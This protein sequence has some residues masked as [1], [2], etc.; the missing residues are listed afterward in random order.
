MVVMASGGGDSTALLDLLAT[1]TIGED[2]RVH[3]FHLNHGIRSE[4]ADADEAFVRDL[5]GSLAVPLEVLRY[6]V[7]AY[8]AEH[9]LNLEDAGRRLRYR[10]V[11]EHLDALLERTSGRS[12]VGRIATGHTR[13]D[14]VETFFM[15]L[16]QGSGPRGLTSLRH[17]RGRIVRPL[18]DC[19]RDD[20]RT[21]LLSRGLAWREDSSNLDTARLRARVRHDLVPVLEEINPRFEE[22]LER[23]LDILA[24]EDTLL[25]EMAEAFADDFTHMEG[26]ALEFDCEKMATLG[27][28]MKRRVVRAALTRTFPE[29]SRIEYSH[30]EALVAGFDDLAFA[31]DLP[32]GL[33]AFRE[34]GRM[35]VLRS[36]E[37]APSVVPGLL[38]LP[39]TIDLGPAGKIVA[40]RVSVRETGG[41]DMSV[42]VDPGASDEFVV[43]HPR[44]GDKMRPLGLGGTKK[45]SD[46]LID[47][48]VPKRLR[49]ATPVVRDGENIVWVAGVRMSDEYKV[50]DETSDAVRLTWSPGSSSAGRDVD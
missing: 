47:A 34:Y 2:L 31:R 28:P 44:E 27:A 45:L 48:K 43:D 15:R 18:L 41:D 50:T 17:V 36:G 4:E 6:D 16:V 26:E 29:A 49:M 5:C 1:G 11:E 13:D 38:P 25:S 40:E 39:G 42:V 14:R 37:E 9:G 46:L 10:F 21:Y 33:R 20:L 8:A 23:S 7:P 3:A 35:I 32:E 22:A 19:S 30:I 24:E 12:P